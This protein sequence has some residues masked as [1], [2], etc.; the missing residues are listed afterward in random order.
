MLD[1]VIVGA[2]EEVNINEEEA[3]YVF[4]QGGYQQNNISFQLYKINNRSPPAIN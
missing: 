1:N 2:E 4:L 3:T